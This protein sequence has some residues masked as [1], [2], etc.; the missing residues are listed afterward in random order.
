MLFGCGAARPDRQL[1]QLVTLP[2]GENMPGSHTEQL[3]ALD[4]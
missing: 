3:R 1:L 4:T 2:P